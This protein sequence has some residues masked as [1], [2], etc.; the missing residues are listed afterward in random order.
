MSA[1][2]D[3][4]SVVQYKDLIGVAD[5]FQTVGNHDDGLVMGQCLD[6][7]LQFIL[8]LRVNAACCLVQNDDRCVLQ[9]GAGDGNPLFLAAGQSTASLANHSV[10]AIRQGR[11]K[12]MAAS[13]LRRLNHLLMGGVRAAKLDIVLNRICKEVYAL[14][15]H[16]DI[17]HQAVQLKIPYI[18]TAY[19][20][21]PGIH[22]PKRAIRLHIVVF[23][24]PEGPTMA[25]VVFSGMVKLT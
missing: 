10:I 20:N 23:P 3:D 14:E 4:M 21:L 22:I 8:I 1:A 9:H 25:V 19:G 6:S 24:A 7:P 15:H 2:L 11:N 12:V 16:R 13:L 5:G 17:L 18:R